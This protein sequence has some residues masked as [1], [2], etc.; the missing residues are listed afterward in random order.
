LASA[1]SNAGG[2]GIITCLTQ[3]TPEDLGRE[4][5]K[6]RALTDRPFGVNLTFLPT[7]STPPYAQYIDVIARSGVRIVET[8]GR[9]P[10]PYMNELKS[11]GIKVIH[12]CT[13]F[14]TR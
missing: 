1:V 14:A 6:C 3:K 2:L 12:K 8:A 7:F 4:I 13:S 9:S 10:D 11:A 5:A